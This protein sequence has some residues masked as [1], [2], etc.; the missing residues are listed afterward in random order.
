[1]S[2]PIF[3]YHH[4]IDSLREGPY[5]S[6]GS[7]PKFWVTYDGQ[8]LTHH[9]IMSELKEYARATRDQELWNRDAQQYIVVGVDISKPF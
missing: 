9:D 5:C 2:K 7:Y 1:M 4:L 3:T 6:V 8:C